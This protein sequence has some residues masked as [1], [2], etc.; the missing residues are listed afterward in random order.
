MTYT[1]A[2]ITDTIQKAAIHTCWQFGG[3]VQRFHGD[4]LFIYFGGRAVTIPQSAVNAINATSFFTYF[5][6]NN[7]KDLFYEQGIEDIYVRTG[8]DTGEAEDVL[9]YKAGVGDCGEITTCSLHTSLAAH[10]QGNASSNGIMIGDNVKKYANLSS[11]LYAIK[12]DSQGKEDRYIYQIPEEN[13]NYTQW[14]FNWERYVNTHPKVMVGLDGR[15]Y[16]QGAAP[17]IIEPQKNM[18]YLR[19]QTQGYKPYFK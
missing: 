2:N 7:L 13:F 14:V 9:W 16:I 3:Y 6:K 15:L 4:G 11:E 18:D 19:Q 17:A 1:V 12:K 10:V 8:I 5:V